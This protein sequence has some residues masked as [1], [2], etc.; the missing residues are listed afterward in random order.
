MQRLRRPDDDDEDVIAAGSGHFGY[1]NDRV[2]RPF[3]KRTPSTFRQ[4]PVFLGFLLCL[5]VGALLSTR[6][7]D[8]STSL[9]GDSRPIIA[10]KEQESPKHPQDPPKSP[11]RPLP[12]IEIP[13]NCTL[14]PNE[15]RTCPMNYPTSF[16]TDDLDRPSTCPD[17]YRWIHEDLRPWK[18]TGITEEMVARAERTATF[19]LTIVDGRAYVVWYRKSYQSRDTF[20]IWGILQL[21]RRYPG[22]VPD[23]DLMFDCVD[24]PVIQKQFYRQHTD[25]QPPPLFRYCG[26]DKS[27][28]IVFPD[29]SFWGW[30]EIN[31]KPWDSLVKE[32]AE[33]NKVTKWVDR[34]THAY[35]KGNPIVAE[36]RMD[37]LKCN[38]SENQDWNAR[39]YA[40]DWLKESQEGFKE[41]N[42]A[43]QCKHRYKIYIEGSAWSVSEKYILACDSLTLLVTPHYYDFFTRSLM[44]VHHYWPIKEDS[45]C[46]SI[47]FAV[48]WGES[49]KKKSQEIG[50][51]ASQFILED[52]K[53][54]YVYD[55]MF[56]LLNE[57]AKL[58]KFKPTIPQKAVEFCSET[59]ACPAQGVAKDFMMESLEK[60]PAVK[61]PC[62]LPPPYDPQSLFALKRRQANSIRQVETWENNYWNTH[63][64]KN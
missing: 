4:A 61:T 17:Y 52:V 16:Q 13:L 26:D 27:L 64:A 39:V 29:W 53:M 9:A 50:K 23:L 19:R 10:T 59:M 34:D 48:D 5:L 12:R 45:K 54:D 35:W 18:D 51:A 25:T 7:L 3:M 42:L 41:S 56:H 44:P 22:K 14:A 30:P 2:W 38:V 6:F 58:L 36:T 46:K 31:I 49:H 33:G 60:G 57:Y 20:T 21:L 32:L 55:Y 28:D 11:K 24:W 62:T 47:K 1:F 15:T 63:S 40:Q 8:L 37:L 43:T